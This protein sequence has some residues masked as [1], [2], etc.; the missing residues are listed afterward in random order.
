MNFRFH[1]SSQ[2]YHS[3]TA[4][5]GMWWGW[6]YGAVLTSFALYRV[7]QRLDKKPVLLDHA[8]MSET[9]EHCTADNTPLRQ[10]LKRE[11]VQLQPVKTAT[12]AQRLNTVFDNFIVGSDQLWRHQYVHEFGT[13]FFLDFVESGKRKIAYAT[14]LGEIGASVPGDFR[15]IVSE[16]LQHFDAISV[17]EFSGIE[18]LKRLYG[19]ECVQTLD[20]VFLPGATFWQNIANSCSPKFADKNYALAYILDKKEATQHGLSDILHSR[21]D[22]SVLITDYEKPL[23]QAEAPQYATILNQISPYEWLAAIA[24]CKF[25]LTDSFHGACFAIIFN[26]P[27]LCLI[28]ERRG[29]T[30]FHTLQKLF[31]T[32]AHRFINTT[33]PLPSDLFELNYAEVNQSLQARRE[34]SLSWLQ[35][36][37][38]LPPKEHGTAAAI[39]PCKKPGKL[40]QALFRLK[41]RLLSK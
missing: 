26:K 17:R 38:Q 13:Q 7:L 29:A 35:Q 23:T 30:R 16:Q 28:N 19:V 33:S 40:R 31:P 12:A 22:E 5:L 3:D 34:Q 25:M 18:E 1:K 41:Q 6:N 24:N 9:W 27:F 11:E 14:S 36:A 37:I 15:S 21:H 39:P 8:P 4:I 32:L 20:P 10:F 2:N